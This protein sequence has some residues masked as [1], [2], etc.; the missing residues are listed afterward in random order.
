LHG[1]VQ[2]WLPKTQVFRNYVDQTALEIHLAEKK[3]RYGE[4]RCDGSDD[5]LTVDDSTRAGAD[6]CFL[7]RKYGHHVIFFVNPYQIISN[8]PYFFSLFDDCLDSRRVDSVSFNG[9]TYNLKVP[10]QL[11]Q[12]RL[13]ARAVLMVLDSTEAVRNVQR[14]ADLLR[15]ERFECP[16]HAVPLRIE[17]LLELKLAGVQIESHGWAHQCITA[18]DADALAQDLSKSSLWLKEALSIESTLYAVPYGLEL[19]PDSAVDQ[20]QEAYFLVNADL[21]T[22]QLGRKCWNRIDLTASIRPAVPC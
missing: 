6:A 3:Q 20:V 7:A 12:F 14:F 19:L 5:V 13:A 15:V 17:D 21:P 9:A 18:L 11:R 8:Q 22:A 4:W 2:G 16:K 10:S 1:C